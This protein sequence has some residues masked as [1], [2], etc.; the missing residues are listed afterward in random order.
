VFLSDRVLVMGTRPGRVLR[1]VT[2]DLPRPRAENVRTEPRF[3]ELSDD[4]WQE[5][6]GQ[7]QLAGEGA[8]ATT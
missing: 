6:R 4:L 8:G 3:R 5:L 7:I 1:D 2:I